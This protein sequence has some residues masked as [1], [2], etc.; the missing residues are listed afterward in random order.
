[1]FFNW[2]NLIHSL[3]IHHEEAT[4]DNFPAHGS[5]VSCDGREIIG[6]E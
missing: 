3:T 4:K 2:Q 5:V 6:P 1:M